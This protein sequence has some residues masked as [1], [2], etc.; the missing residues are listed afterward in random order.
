MTILDDLSGFE[1]E[2]VMED[3][4]RKLGYRNVRQSEKTGDEGRDILMEERVNGQ[5][6]GIVV[7][8]KHRDR[9][10]RPVVQKL[11]SAV[12]T[13]DFDGPKRGIIVTTGSFTDQAREY[14]HKLRERGD[15][16]EIQLI[17]GSELRGMA[18]DVGLNLYNGRIEVV[19]DRTLRP[20]DPA[21]GIDKPVRDAFQK[22]ANL[23]ARTLPAVDS[24]VRFEPVVSIDARTN[25]TFETSVGVI[26]R[27]DERDRL[28]L[29]A[30]GETPRIATETIQQLVADG[31]QHT[32]GLDDPRVVDSFARR[33][34]DH[35]GQSETD[36]K[37]WTVDRLRTRYTT[38]V[39]YTGDNNVDYEKECEPKVS[40]VSIRSISPV[41][42]PRILSRTTLKDHEYSL[43]YYAA[44]PSRATIENGI[45]QCV[46]CGGTRLKHTYCDNC[47]SINCRRHTKT[48]R[49]EGDPVCTG[50]AV[51]DRFALRK[52]YFYDEGNLE[53]FR[54][55]Y[56][57]LPA[58]M[59]A[60]ENKPMVA[61]TV[62]MV[63]FAMLFLI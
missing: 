6:R 63:L 3:V 43:E 10:G 37:E 44:G 13:Y 55:E 38:T 20:V 22:I 24:T 8:C 49:L 61:S 50:C 56:D 23:D 45:G 48:E 54:E 32:V 2:D 58:H 31:G 47:G 53:A 27:V 16:T 21:G 26:H 33:E 30:D 35:F 1:F 28:L 12:T 59:K 62:A 41:Y 29:S 15:G 52:R 19:C 25:A 60:M 34:A 17:G 36:Y 9:V 4:F 39:E 7:E 11:H 57:E 51:S 18:N 14:T 46:H 40:D 5:R 42:V